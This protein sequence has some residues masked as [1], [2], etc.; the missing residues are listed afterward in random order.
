VRARSVTWSED[1]VRTGRYRDLTT[2]ETELL[3]GL[4]DRDLTTLAGALLLDTQLTSE[5][6]QA[7]SMVIYLCQPRQPNRF[8]VSHRWSMPI[9]EV[10]HTIR[11]NA[12][13]CT[14]RSV[15]GRRF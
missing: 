12:C 6:L 4:V 2:T 15:C 8:I 5:E 9:E 10:G 11:E 1:E 7:V 14:C 13:R 3:D